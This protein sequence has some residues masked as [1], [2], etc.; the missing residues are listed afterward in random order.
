MP[1]NP[2]DDVVDFALAA[3]NRE[4]ANLPEQQEEPFAHQELSPEEI[5]EDFIKIRLDPLAWSKMAAQRGL[6]ET[7]RYNTIMEAKYQSAQAPGVTAVVVPTAPTS[8]AG[9]QGVAAPEGSNE[10]GGV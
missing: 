3:L 8:E 5:L 6:R 7:G 10:E 1:T 4:I 2:L 9:E